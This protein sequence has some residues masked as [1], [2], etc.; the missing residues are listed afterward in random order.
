MPD[1]ITTII[2]ELKE[3]GAMIPEKEWGE[4]CVLGHELMLNSSI[5]AKVIAFELLI[6]HGEQL[7][8]SKINKLIPE[9]STVENVLGY[10]FP[11][12]KDML[13]PY[14]VD[15]IQAVEKGD[16]IFAAS[17]LKTYSETI[18]KYLPNW[19]SQCACIKKGDII[20]G[21]HRGLEEN[22]QVA[23]SDIHTIWQDIV[24]ALNR[25]G[26]LTAEEARELVD[27]VRL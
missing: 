1:K 3:V 14:L 9:I 24:S 16:Y 8:T 6:S 10:L 11:G 5:E 21:I 23:Q 22:S 7:D 18:E 4:K 19:T 20:E 25:R 26:I 15:A 2:N 12:T 27:A 17:K 13:E